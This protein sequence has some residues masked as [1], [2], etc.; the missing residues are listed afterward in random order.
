M[1]SLAVLGSFD[2]KNTFLPKRDVLLLISSKMLKIIR[3][4]YFSCG[5]KRDFFWQFPQKTS[6]HQKSLFLLHVAHFDEKNTF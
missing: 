1:L 3:N 4:A 2:E 6:K 5:S